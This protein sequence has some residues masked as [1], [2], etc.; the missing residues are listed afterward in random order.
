MSCIRAG[1]HLRMAQECRSDSVASGRRTLAAT[2]QTFHLDLEPISQVWYTEPPSVIGHR[3]SCQMLSS[4][5]RDKV[6]GEHAGVEA[7]FPFLF[8]SWTNM[9][10]VDEWEA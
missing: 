9:V 7:L 1:E 3:L 8:F 4:V 5:G 6:D 10:C 2:C